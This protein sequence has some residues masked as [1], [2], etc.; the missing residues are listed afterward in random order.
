VFFFSSLEKVQKMSATHYK[1]ILF[2]KTLFL[3]LV[4]V[5]SPSVA[6]GVDITKDTTVSSDLTTQHIITADDTTLTVTGSIKYSG[7]QAVRANSRTNP[8][9]VVNS[10]A[11]IATVGTGTDFGINLTSSTGATVTNSGTISAVDQQAVRATSSTNATITNNAGG[12]ISAAN[13]T[14]LA[15]NASVSGLTITNSGKIYNTGGEATVRIESSS[16]TTVTNNAGGEIY[17]TGSGQVFK[18]GD[19]HTLTNSGEIRND[20]ST[21]NRAIWFFGDDS[22]VTLKEGSILVGRLNFQAGTTGST[23]KVEQGYGQSYFYDTGNGTGTY[24]VEDLSGNAIVKGSAASVGQG[25]QETVDERLGLRTFNL[26][27]ALTR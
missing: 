12:V 3:V 21:S 11:T 26:R 13:N 14:I 17:T 10:G 23:L 9:V 7:S 6:W 24:T 2:P 19:S 18:L 5:L 16:A 4:L 25:A 8:T 22:T 15:H 20:T 1:N 27:S